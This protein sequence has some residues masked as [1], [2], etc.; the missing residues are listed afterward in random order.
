MIV[1]TLVGQFDN[2][3]DLEGSSLLVVTRSVDVDFRIS[4]R[5]CNGRSETVYGSDDRGCCRLSPRTPLVS[6]IS[7]IVENPRQ[8]PFSCPHK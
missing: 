2:L 8:L 6:M 7:E 1:E 3:V 5:L 4:S